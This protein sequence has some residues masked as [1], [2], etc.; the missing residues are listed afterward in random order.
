MEDIMDFYFEDEEKTLKRLFMTSLTILILLLGIDI[1]F[2]GTKKQEEVK[3]PVSAIVYENLV[4]SDKNGKIKLKNFDSLS[5]REYNNIKKHESYIKKVS[6]DSTSIEYLGSL[7]KREYEKY[8]MNLSTEENIINS[9]IAYTEYSR[10]INT[11]ATLEKE[12]NSKYDQF[13]RSIPNKTEKLKCTAASILY[14]LYKMLMLINFIVVIMFIEISEGSLEPISDIFTVNVPSGIIYFLLD[15]STQYE[16][17]DLRKP[18]FIIAILLMTL[19]LF[20]KLIKVDK[21]LS[22]YKMIKDFEKSL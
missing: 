17:F 1:L 2:I 7:S 10:E 3:F 13:K 22:K 5:K 9:Y 18:I 19:Y 12:L 6:M 15:K 14:G 16:S 20:L 21:R 8:S 11:K 4:E